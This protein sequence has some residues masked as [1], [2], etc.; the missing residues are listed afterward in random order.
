MSAGKGTRLSKIAREFNVGISTIVEFLTKKGYE[1]DSNPNSKI[2]SDI[3]DI[4]VD[5][6]STDIS[7]KKES[8]RLSFKNLRDEKE[9]ISIN[10]LDQQRP[11]QQTSEEE[12]FIKD[13]SVK[14][15]IEMPEAKEDEV[16]G[17]EAAKEEKTSDKSE[18]VPDKKDEDEPGKDLK[19]VGKIDLDTVAGKRKPATKAKKAEPGEKEV[20]KEDKKAEKKKG[21]AEAGKAKNAKE[22]VKAEGKSETEP[23]T[24]ADELVQT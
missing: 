14:G 1:V 4:L 16:V 15:S 7:A 22:K 21:T 24:I 5:E 10:D 18:E 13:P 23:E 12:V 9:T 17:V 2:S 20:P 3:Y 19:V 6:Y 8:D 11:S